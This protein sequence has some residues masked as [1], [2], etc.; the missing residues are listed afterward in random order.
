MTLDAESSV[1][2]KVSALL[3]SAASK[4]DAPCHPDHGNRRERT[5]RDTEDCQIL[6][7]CCGYS[8]SMP[9]VT[10]VKNQLDFLS[11]AELY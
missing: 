5:A 10:T 6:P 2:R 3:I 1:Q 8:I 7:H 4:R 11:R 9:R